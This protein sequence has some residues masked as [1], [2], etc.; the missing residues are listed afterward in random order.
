[1]ID[2]IVVDEGDPDPGPKD[3][4]VLSCPTVMEGAAGRRALAERVLEFAR[5]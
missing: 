1:M 4:P 5:A 2:A 3:I